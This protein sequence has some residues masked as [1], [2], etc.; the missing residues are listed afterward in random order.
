MK[1]NEIKQLDNGLQ[2]KPYAD[3][4][5]KWVI[6]VRGN[7]NINRDE[8]LEFCREYLRAAKREKTEYFAAIRDTNLGFNEHMNIICGHYYTLESDKYGVI[9]TYTVVEEYID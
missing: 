8:I 3:H 4:I 5:Y 1:I 6:D 9:W 7:G 2:K